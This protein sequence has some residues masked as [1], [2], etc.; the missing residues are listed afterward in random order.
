M[1]RL[2]R[3][4][5]ITLLDFFAWDYVKFKVYMNKTATI[6]ELEAKVTHI[7]RQIA[8][9]MLKRVI[10]NWNLRMDYVSRNTANVWKKLCFKN[11]C[12][13]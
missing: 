2:S 4:C 7:I 6:E 11:K 10:E 9:E 5:D 12:Q 1:N 13:I 8:L 3:F